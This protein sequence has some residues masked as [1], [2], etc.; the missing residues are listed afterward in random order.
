MLGFLFRFLPDRA[1]FEIN[2]RMDMKKPSTRILTSRNRD[3]LPHLPSGFNAGQSRHGS[4]HG[5]GGS[6]SA[7][8]LKACVPNQVPASGIL[9]WPSFTFSQNST[10][11][12]C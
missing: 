2:H 9:R 10:T 11:L 4:A 12:M 7:P 1:D 6:Q 3:I 8:A 5:A